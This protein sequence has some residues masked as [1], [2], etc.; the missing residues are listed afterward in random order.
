[1]RME[2]KKATEIIPPGFLIKFKLKR[3]FIS[4]TL[5]STTKEASFA[6]QKLYYTKRSAKLFFKLIIFLI[7]TVWTRGE[8]VL[9]LNE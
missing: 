3:N 7:V 9:I 4:W 1:M 6:K 8:F 5:W 2:F